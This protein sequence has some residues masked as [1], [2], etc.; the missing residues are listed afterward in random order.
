VRAATGEGL[1]PMNLTHTVTVP[2]LLWTLLGLLGLFV[3]SMNLR[4][5][6]HDVEALELTHVNGALRMVA[7]GNATEETLR[8]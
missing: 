5:A 4:D 2:E 8:V 3:A 7:R 1:E 6:L